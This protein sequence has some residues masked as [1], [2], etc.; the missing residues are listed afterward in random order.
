VGKE[1]GFLQPKKRKILANQL[2]SG[3]VGGNLKL[4]TDQF[5]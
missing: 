4:K 3:F 1:S 5:V 2:E